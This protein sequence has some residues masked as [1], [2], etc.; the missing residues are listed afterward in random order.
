MKF[1]AFSSSYGGLQV[2]SSHGTI[3]TEF[4][5]SGKAWHPVYASNEARFE[6]GFWD[7]ADQNQAIKLSGRHTGVN[8]FRLILFQSRLFAVRS[9]HNTGDEDPQ[10]EVRQDRFLHVGKHA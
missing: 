6:Q 5:P 7:I 8:V 10:D 4:H 2:R 9:Q 3:Q 1:I